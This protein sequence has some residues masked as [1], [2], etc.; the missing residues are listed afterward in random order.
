MQH[1]NQKRVW[2]HVMQAVLDG[3]GACVIGNNPSSNP[4]VTLSMSGTT[5]ADNLVSCIDYLLHG[6]AFVIAVM[7]DTQHGAE[8]IRQAEGLPSTYIQL[9]PLMLHAPIPTHKPPGHKRRWSAPAGCKVCHEGHDIHQQRSRPGT[10][11]SWRWHPLPHHQHFLIHSHRPRHA[12]LDFQ[13][14]HGM[15]PDVHNS[16]FIL[17]SPVSAVLIRI[18]MR[19]AS[20]TSGSTVNSSLLQAA[21]GGGVYVLKESV[22]PMAV[23]CTP[24]CQFDSNTAVSGTGSAFM[25]VKQDTTGGTPGGQLTLTLDG[26]LAGQHMPLHRS[27]MTGARPVFHCAR[28]VAYKPI[29]AC[30][31]R[32]MMNTLQLK[33]LPRCLPSL[34]F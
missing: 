24:T 32:Q 34:L 30:K 25:S 27:C 13:L 21:A 7:D 23:R 33:L 11:W 22:Q 20:I 6:D 4:T 17:V 9:A 3:G 1:T 19:L 26:T 18:A 10:W 2:L 8:A 16:L 31:H 29:V 15:T 28:F 14:K 5:I 12:D